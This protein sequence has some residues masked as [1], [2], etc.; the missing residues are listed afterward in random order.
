MSRTPLIAGNWKMNGDR[1][2]A[3][4]WVAAVAP[5]VPASV[6]ALACPPFPYLDVLRSGLAGSRLRL[7]GQDLAAEREGACTSGVSGEM[8]A[9]LG[10]SHVIVGHSERRLS[11][12]DDQQVARKCRRARYAALM[13]ILCVGETLAER[14]AGETVAVVARQLGAVLNGASA[15]LLEGIIVAYE[16]IWA[17]G[18]GH[19]ATPEQAQAVHAALRERV[20]G[21]D[22]GLAESLRVLYGGSVK[23][24]NAASLMAQP[25]ID[26]ALIGGASLDPDSF[27]AIC[28]AAAS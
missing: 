15:D 23:A 10:C 2:M 4:D 18:T 16:P 13:P 5:A 25:D 1:A 24:D 7:G 21:H 19:N 12:E 3:A 9:D 14:E 6:E 17:I 8:L 26:G 28:Q 27:L 20:A 11:G 22:V